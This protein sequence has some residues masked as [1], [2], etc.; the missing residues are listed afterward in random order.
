[1]NLKLADR[2]KLSAVGIDQAQTT[3]IIARYE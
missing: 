2:L 1:M 3:S